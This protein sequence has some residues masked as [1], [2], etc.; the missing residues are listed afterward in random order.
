M[1]T[2]TIQGLDNGSRSAEAY[3]SKPR[4]KRKTA[5]KGLHNPLPVVFVRPLQGRS[6]EV[7]LP[8]ASVGLRSTATIVFPRRGKETVEALRD[9]W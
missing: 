3:G 6:E 4:R 9:I 7:G 8:H 1:L 2:Y 5:L